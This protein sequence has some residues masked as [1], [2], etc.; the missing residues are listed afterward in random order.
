LVIEQVPRLFEEE[1]RMGQHE[2]DVVHPLLGLSFH[3]PSSRDALRIA[4]MEKNSDA[5]D[6][7]LVEVSEKIKFDWPEFLPVE[8]I[9]AGI[10]EI[11]IGSIAFAAIVAFCCF[12]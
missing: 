1:M 9:K 7:E 5:P 12:H 10:T 8:R 4:A 6:V 11:F 2:A 3:L